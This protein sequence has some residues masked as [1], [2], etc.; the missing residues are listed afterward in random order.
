[1]KRKGV[2]YDVGRVMYGNWRPVFDLQIVHRELEI[3]KNDLHCNAVRICG[4][5]I[6]RLITAAEDALNLGLEVWLSP[7]KWDS[8][9]E[10]TLVYI[11][12][13]A[14][15]A[16]LLRQRYPEH[17]VFSIG[18]E[19]TLFMQGIVTGRNLMARLGHP[20][21]C[22]TI[23]AGKHNQPLNMFLAQATA[24][25]RKAFRG[26]LTYAALLWEAVDWDLFDVVGVDHYR[27]VRIKDRYEEMLKPHF[28]H[29][30]PVVVTE[31][32]CCTDQG[33]EDAGGRAWGVI[34][35]KTLFLHQIPLLG[36]F[37][38][39]RL[40]GNYVRDEG[41]QAREVVEQLYAL[42]H[43]GVDG[44]FIMTF[45]ATNNPY[46]DNPRY[47]LDMP[48]YSLV[49]TLTDGKHGTTYPDMTWEPKESF[50]AVAEYFARS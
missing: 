13:A 21:F 45:V 28:E 24:A 39:P 6:D 43:A 34:D 1:M 41:L 35:Y 12:K 37:V 10:K 8:S 5:S 50:R 48:S 18:S 2:C 32:G 29:G 31:F 15:A 30:K 4:L 44:A 9:P 3:I 49:K 33:A 14:A 38:Q 17:L 27:A 16:E 22:D 42:D 23:K 40:K 19:L 20:T 47:D 26:R 36:K 25:V 11:T 46:N 7:E